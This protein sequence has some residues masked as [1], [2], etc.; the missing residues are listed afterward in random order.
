[1][2]LDFLNLFKRKALMP[3]QDD[4]RSLSVES[5]LQ[6]LEDGFFIGHEFIVWGNMLESV[7]MRHALSADVDAR[8]CKGKPARY[9]GIDMAGMSI[10]CDGNGQP[11]TQAWYNIAKPADVGHSDF[12]GRRHAELVK[13]LG[14]PGHG[15]AKA[16][17]LQPAS[18]GSVIAN[19][20]W[21]L[22]GV[23]VGVSWY[24]SP[25]LENGINTSG[26]LYATWDDELA[27][28]KPYIGAWQERQALFDKIKTITPLAVLEVAEQHPKS[29][30]WFHFDAKD[31]CNDVSLLTAQR[32]LRA[33][34]LLFTPKRLARESLCNATTLL[35]W[36][37][38]SSAC[39]GL[40]NRFDT[41]MFP[42][43]SKVKVNWD[44]IAPAKGA[45]GHFVRVGGL[46]A[47]RP[48][49]AAKSPADIEAF[50][51]KLKTISGVEVSIYDSSDC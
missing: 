2:K 32:A 25:R 44:R 33:P 3:T 7:S 1:M 18:S 12:I 22:G 48:F 21:R 19:A 23:R 46:T 41:A 13:R 26:V 28:A 29:W 35:A 24:G 11:V 4:A 27:I 51:D 15:D 45:G 42:I 6:K 34:N 40:S 31:P 39:W 36:Q 17:G 16:K 5:T 8:W 43:G 38:E 9:F 14:R 37:D 20:E 30:K 50:L 49:D 10:G 47:S